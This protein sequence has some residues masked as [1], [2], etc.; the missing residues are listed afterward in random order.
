MPATPSEGPQVRSAATL[1]EPDTEK[2]LMHLSAAAVEADLG[3]SAS[4]WERGENPNPAWWSYRDAAEAIRRAE[5]LIEE[6]RRRA[7]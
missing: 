2:A 5:R 4:T 1:R 7:R 3:M 6:A